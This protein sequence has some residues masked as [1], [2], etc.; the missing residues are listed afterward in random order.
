MKSKYFDNV[1][2]TTVNIKSF[3]KND[4]ITWRAGNSILSKTSFILGMEVGLD[5][6]T[7]RGADLYLMGYFTMDKGPGRTV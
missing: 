7:Q 4:F 1:A 2:T 6:G 3:T 5:P